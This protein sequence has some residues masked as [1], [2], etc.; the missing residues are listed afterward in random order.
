MSKYF[1]DVEFPEPKISPGEPKQPV[2]TKFNKEK[3][4]AA[5]EKIRQE[6][7]KIKNGE[8]TYT[9]YAINPGSFGFPAANRLTMFVDNPT[10]ENL[11][12]FV[13]LTA[14]DVNTTA[15]EHFEKMLQATIEENPNA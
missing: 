14:Q 10:K 2:V 8:S 3:L 11:K 5:V 6:F 15:S 9:H 1:Q 7:K 13:E 4:D 12:A